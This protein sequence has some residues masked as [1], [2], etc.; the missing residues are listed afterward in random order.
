MHDD[1]SCSWLCCSTRINFGIDLVPI[2]DKISSQPAIKWMILLIQFHSF[3]F[4]HIQIFGNVLNCHS[5]RMLQICRKSSALMHCICNV[6]SV[7]FLDEIQLTNRTLVMPF[8]FDFIEHITV[9]VSVKLDCQWC[10]WCGFCSSSFIEVQIIQ[11]ALNQIE[12]E[13]LWLYHFSTIQSCCQDNFTCIISRWIARI[14]VVSARLMF[15][16]SFWMIGLDSC[17]D[18]CFWILISIQKALLLLPWW[19][20]KVI[21]SW[22]KDALFQ[23]NRQTWRGIEVIHV[24]S[25]SWASGLPCV[26]GEV[27][28]QETI[29][30]AINHPT[31]AI[32]SQFA[33]FRPGHIPGNR[34]H[35]NVWFWEILEF[36]RSTWSE[37]FLLF[38]LGKKLCTLFAT[39]IAYGHKF[40][41]TWCAVG[42]WCFACKIIALV[43]SCKSRILFSACPFILRKS[44]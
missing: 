33:A 14:C 37:R 22:S 17:L 27:T 26:N 36:A 40:A 10:C 19:L 38:I 16:Q 23:T 39:L 5:M 24:Q 28:S 7:W 9:H 25:P 32:S 11:H 2:T 12:V 41:V 29:Q 3:I 20:W 13:S 43:L 8:L 34:M 1:V 44:W 21:A 4:C 15:S 35:D 18:W 30:C 42:R 31:S 6:W